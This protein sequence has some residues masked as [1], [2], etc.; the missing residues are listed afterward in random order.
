[1]KKAA[2]KGGSFFCQDLVILFDPADAF[3]TVVPIDLFDHA[4]AAMPAI[5][6]P[7]ALADTDLDLRFGG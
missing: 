4:E 5:P 3:V 1:M 2:P 7:A 6:M